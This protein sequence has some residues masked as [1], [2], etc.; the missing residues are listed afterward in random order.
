MFKDRLRQKNR[1]KYEREVQRL[2]LKD[3]NGRS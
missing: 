2:I 3:F 1:D